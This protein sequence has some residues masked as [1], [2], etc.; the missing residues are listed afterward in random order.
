MQ[1]SNTQLEHHF[2]KKTPAVQAFYSSWVPYLSHALFLLACIRF[3]F[4]GILPSTYN[5][6]HRKIAYLKYTPRH[7]QNVFI[8]SCKFQCT[9]T[10]ALPF[11]LS[12]CEIRYSGCYLKKLPA[13]TKDPGRSGQQLFGW[14]MMEKIAEAT[15]GIL[16]TTTCS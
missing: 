14:M 2:K 15:T 9:E 3:V 1:V 5:N 4:V 13:D 8:P 7:C 12:S 6:C 10:V 11:Y 16:R